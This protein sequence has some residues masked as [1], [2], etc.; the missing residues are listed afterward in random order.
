MAEQ[1]KLFTDIERQ[2]IVLAASSRRECVSVS[3]N[4]VRRGLDWLVRKLAGD[5]SGNPLA[6][7]RLEA[8]R[9][10]ACT[11]FAT[12]GQPAETSIR[13]A[14]QAGFSRDQIEGLKRLASGFRA[15]FG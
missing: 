5:T 8:L 2:V 1:L 9:R 13:S 3:S 12:D 11:S 6:N 10:L 14:L 7:E 4:P 15:R